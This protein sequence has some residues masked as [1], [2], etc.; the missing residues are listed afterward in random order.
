M[1]CLLLKVLAEDG[2]CICILG[3]VLIYDVFVMNL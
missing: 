1:L 2:I 3:F